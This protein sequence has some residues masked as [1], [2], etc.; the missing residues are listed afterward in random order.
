MSMNVDKEIVRSAFTIGAVL[1]HYGV[2]ILRNEQVRCPFHGEDRTPSASIKNGFFYCFVCNK[3][4]DIYGFI[5]EMEQ[6][7]F[8]TSLKLAAKMAGLPTHNTRE[9]KAVLAQTLRR[10]S[11]DSSEKSVLTCQAVENM[12]YWQVLRVS[13]AFKSL[14][15]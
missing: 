6:C 13:T 5:M 14:S 4:R 8:K 9:S 10:R 3:P 2:D 11:H 1:Q 12:P 7:D 15:G